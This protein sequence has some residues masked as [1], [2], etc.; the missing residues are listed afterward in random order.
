V[1][2]ACGTPVLVD[3]RLLEVDVGEWTGLTEPEVFALAPA[4]ALARADGR[5]F[6]LSRT[7][8]LAT[9][10]GRRVSTAVA[11]IAAA[12]PGKRIL[13]VSH[14]YALQAA[15]GEL[16]DWSLEQSRR[17]DGLF[18]CAFTELE[19]ETGRWKLVAHNVCHPQI[20]EQRTGEVKTV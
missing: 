13:V 8:E 5:D 6:R 17:V 19:V 14:G 20:P 10:C 1:A 2:T 16:L 11:E 15:L 18:N 7:G 3:D 9:E 12:N 4:F